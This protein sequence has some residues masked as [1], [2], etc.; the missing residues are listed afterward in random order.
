M[1]N[2]VASQPWV[3]D[4]V[5]NTPIFTGFMNIIHIA[6]TGYTDAAHSVE[7]QDANGRT[8]CHLDG[9]TDLEEIPS[10]FTGTV[11]G[12]KVPLLQSAVFGSIAN[13]PS[14]ELIIGFQ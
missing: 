4:T 5:S 7:L 6:Y 13:M 3:I 10:Y 2:Q 8:I 1:G 12:I 14:G 11:Q 9:N